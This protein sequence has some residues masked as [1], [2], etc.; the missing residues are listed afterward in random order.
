MSAENIENKVG[1]DFKGDD[2]QHRS[3]GSNDW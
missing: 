2:P 1:Q 3:L